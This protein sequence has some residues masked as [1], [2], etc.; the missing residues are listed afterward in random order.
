[1]QPPVSA[2]A[3]SQQILVDVLQC[4]LWALPLGLLAHQ[5]FGERVVSLARWDGRPRPG[6]PADM[7]DMMVA[8]LLM[9]LLGTRLVGGAQGSASASPLPPP[10]SGDVI[11]GATVQI[12]LWLLLV[13]YLRGWRMRGLTAWLGLPDRRRLVGLIPLSLIWGVLG[14]FA[15]Y[16]VAGLANTW[17]WLPLGFEPEPQASVRALAESPSLLAR[18]LMAVTACVVAPV[19]EE[20]VFRGFLYPA[21]RQ[22]ADVPFAAVFTSVLFGVVHGSLG[23]L[24]PL[25]VLGIV[26][27]LAYEWSRGIALPIGIHAFFN[28]AT[29]ARLWTDALP[30][31]L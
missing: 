4:L 12:F 26:L 9:Y 10:Q 6:T 21:L 30:S 2:N 11:A 23:A 3:A 20:T 5:W 19:V 27:V 1:M 7:I 14:V 24:I 17:I 16:A 8:L 28:L 18:G 22:Y 25:A 15:V 13:G 31:P 29:T